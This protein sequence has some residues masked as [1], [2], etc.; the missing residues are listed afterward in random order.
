MITRIEID[1]FKAF[2]KFTLDLGPFQTI[3]GVNGSGKSNLFDALQLL[4]RLVETDLR[5]AFQQGRGEANELFTIQPTGELTNIMRFAVELL[6][7]RQVQDSWGAE[8]EL[9][10]T[11]MRYE[12]YIER[13]SDERGLERLYVIHEQLELIPRGEDHWIKR[14]IGKESSHWLPTLTIERSTPFISTVEKESGIATISLHQ[15]GHRER[16]SRVAEKVERTILSGVTNTEFPHA[17]AVHEEI[18][19][20]KFLHLNPDV[21]REPSSMVANPYMEPDGKNLPS[22]LARMESLDPL[23]L[24]DVSRDIAYLVPGVLTVDIEKDTVRDRYI[25]RVQME[26]GQF[27]TARVLSDGTLRL[28]ALATLKHDPHH[29][30]VLCFE[31]PENGVHPFRLN[32]LSQI[33]K[34]LTTDF[35]D[36]E[37]AQEPLRQLLV[38]THSP[39]FVSQKNIIEGLLFA[40]MSKRVLPGEQHQ[41]ARITRLTPV[42]KPGTQEL[43]DLGLSKQELTYTLDQVKHYLTSAD[44]SEVLETIQQER[45]SV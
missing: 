19:S 13:R 3:V 36:Q 44:V 35:S 32:A 10:Y 2:Q 43:L 8:A 31:E 7:D 1:G 25:I 17:F 9:K 34:D 12:V 20:W 4:A 39:V 22:V 40:H 5:S 37:Q 11:R 30:G 18:R 21:L 28:L 29:S 45:E 33:L 23:L 41:P 42:M 16:K 14:Y 24:N 27:F 6:V 38:N 15:D 26:D